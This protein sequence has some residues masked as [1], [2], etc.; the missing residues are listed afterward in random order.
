M[1]RVIVKCRYYKNAATGNLGGLLKYIATREGVELLPKEQQIQPVSEKQNALV[2]QMV[3]RDPRLKKTPEYKKYLN[4]KSQ[5]AASEFIAAAIEGNPLLL[6]EESYLRYMALR[7][8]AER[9]AGSHGLFSFGDEPIRLE[10][11]VAKLEAHV[12]NVY[13]VIISLKREDAERLGYNNAGRWRDMI[14][15]HIDQIAEEHHIPVTALRWYG[16]FHNESYHPHVHLLLYST[17]EK[18]TAYLP[19][20]GI[21]NLRSLFAKEIFRDD[22]RE[23]YDRQTEMRNRITEAMRSEFRMLVSEV[24]NGGLVNETLLTK[25]EHLALR[26]NGCIGKKQYGYLPKGIKSLVDEIVDDVS[27]DE[28]IRRMYEI[29]YRTK[30]SVTASYTDN[31]PE[32]LPLSAESV[33]KQVRNALVYEADRLG[34][35]LTR[36]SLTDRQTSANTQTGAEKQISIPDRRQYIMNAALRFGSSITRVF[37]ENFHRYDP[38]EDDDIDKKL[39]REIW[40]VKNGM[41]PTL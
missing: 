41:M 13:S 8:R 15:A 17:S 10:D 26:L 39:R 7:P 3:S 11:E 22:L 25:L 20:Q 4:E 38:D 30:F 21:D 35:E 36:T 16:A 2:M 24:Q 19:K 28:R 6:N 27:K 29:W 37:Y 33:F 31:P 34:R 40:A 23:I 9:I 5:G 32:K 12:G 1:P 14:R 18:D